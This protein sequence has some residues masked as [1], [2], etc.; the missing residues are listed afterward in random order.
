MSLVVSFMKVLIGERV[1]ANP[2]R[3]SQTVG[4]QYCG[5]RPAGRVLSAVQDPINEERAQRARSAVMDT[6]GAAKLR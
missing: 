1:P 2:G 5:C 6:P 4:R 3:L